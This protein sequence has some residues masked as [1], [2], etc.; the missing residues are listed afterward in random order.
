[1][2]DWGTSPILPRQSHHRTVASAQHG[3][4]VWEVFVLSSTASHCS[5]GSKIV[6]ATVILNENEKYEYHPEVY[7]FVYYVL[8]IV[9]DT[10]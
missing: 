7:T 1:M 10:R 4:S 9:G 2:E 8:L 5:I 6:C 3:K